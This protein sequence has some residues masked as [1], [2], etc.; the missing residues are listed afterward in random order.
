MRRANENGTATIADVEG[1]EPAGEEGKD[2]AIL[3]DYPSWWSEQGQGAAWNPGTQLLW[4]VAD[5]RQM[6]KPGEEV[7]VKGWMRKV[8]LGKGGDVLGFQ[9]VRHE[10]ELR[11]RD[12]VGNDTSKGDAKR[13]RAGRFSISR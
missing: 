9:N 13:Q 7:K 3:P 10:G 4:Y 12:A 2:V 5:D 6:Y 11:A 1:G 8:D